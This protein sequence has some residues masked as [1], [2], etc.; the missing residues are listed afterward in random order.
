MAS[1]IP[2]TKDPIQA[3]VALR[4]AGLLASGQANPVT[5]PAKMAEMIVFPTEEGSKR[6]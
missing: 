4:G 6:P 2:L 5:N 3:R 1:R